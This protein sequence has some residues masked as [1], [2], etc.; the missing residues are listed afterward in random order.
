MYQR[1]RY[2]EHEGIGK[3]GQRRCIRCEDYSAGS[4]QI[5]VRLYILW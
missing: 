4:K 5:A 1:V 2:M 3:K